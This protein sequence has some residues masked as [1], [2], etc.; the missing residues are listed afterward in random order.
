MPEL[1]A[2]FLVGALLSEITVSLAVQSF[3]KV[4][5]TCAWLEEREG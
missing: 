1:S 3:L 4:G 2:A 5:D